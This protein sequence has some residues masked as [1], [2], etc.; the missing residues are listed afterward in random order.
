MIK[1]AV[2]SLLWRTGLS[3][4]IPPLFWK[5]VTSGPQ[6]KVLS[7]RE[8]QLSFPVQFEDERI[9]KSF[10]E[11]NALFAN[12]NDYV[13]EVNGPVLIE[14]VL[15]LGIISNGKFLAETR[16]HPY[17]YPDTLQYWK[18]KAGLAPVID[19][20]E[21]VHFDGYEGDNYYNFFGD[22][23]SAYC[24][25]LENGLPGGLPLIIG[26]GVYNKPYFQ[27]LL[28]NNTWFKELPWMVL[29][30]KTFIRVKKLY[31]SSV[32]LQ[33]AGVW[34]KAA[35]LFSTHSVEKPVRKIFLDRS[36]KIGRCLSNMEAIKPVLEK[37]GFEI[38]DT[39]GMPIGEQSKLFAGTS[40]L[41]AIHGA[42]ITN[43][44]FSNAQKLSLLEILPGQMLNTHY[45]WLAAT[46]G[47]KYDAILGAN[48]NAQK[49]F[50]LQPSILEHHITK[51]LA[52]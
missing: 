49:Q 23:L 36:P 18:Y 14:P 28:K 31:K 4:S 34:K 51:M 52:D 11:Q 27:W 19:I 38:V 47:C 2:R 33:D 40:H 39:A 46:L 9:S 1:R 5:P 29:D 3:R 21:A 22:V 17:I 7:L 43:I 25:G 45:Y 26:Q 6:L 8:R 37:Y 41:I 13:L 35:T 42:G 16:N 15:G 12:V 10:K 48:M 32:L 50:V 44:I 24:W 30:G 20:A